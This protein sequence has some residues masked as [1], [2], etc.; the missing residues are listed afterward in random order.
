MKIN[1]YSPPVSILK[2]VCVKYYIKFFKQHLPLNYI[3]FKSLMG[4]V[5]SPKK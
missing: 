2:L 3:Y 1:Y 5:F 4:L